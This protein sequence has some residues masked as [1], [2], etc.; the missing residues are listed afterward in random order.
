M[1][2]DLDEVRRSE[3]RRGRP[4]TISE[5]ERRQLQ[6]QLERLYEGTLQQLMDYLE[7]LG[8]EPNSK[9]WNDAIAAWKDDS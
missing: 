5:A 9:R 2:D 8:V 1:D 6:R 4:R 7:R 3:S